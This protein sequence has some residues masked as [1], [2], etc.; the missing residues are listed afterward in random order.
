MGESLPMGQQTWLLSFSPSLSSRF[1]LFR[2]VTSSLSLSLPPLTMSQPPYPPPGNGY[3]FSPNLYG[4]NSVPLLSSQPLQSGSGLPP[5]PGANYDPYGHLPQTQYYH[6]PPLQHPQNLRLPSVAQAGGGGYS[7]QTNGPPPAGVQPPLRPASAIQDPQG[8]L[9]GNGQGGPQRVPTPGG[10]G[11]PPTSGSAS[12]AVSARAPPTPTM[13]GG[14]LQHA[15]STGTGGGSSATGQNSPQ[16]STA[17]GSTLPKARS[18]MAC[19]LCRRQK[20]RSSVP[21]FILSDRTD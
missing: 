7:F 4:Q 12:P 16:Q 17:S 1:S 20:V 19:V 18:A 10:Y 5:P 6:Q 8:L 15:Q 2:I 14:A 11:L 9:N 13:A 3:G 21:F